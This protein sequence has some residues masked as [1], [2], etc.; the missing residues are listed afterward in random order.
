MKLILIV[1]DDD[2]LKKAL[3]IKLAE[4]PDSEIILAKNGVEG[5]KQALSK[6]PDLILLD[7]IMPHLDGVGMLEKLRQDEWGRQAKVL[8]LTNVSDNE[9]IARCTELGA[10]EYL[11]KA[12]R[13]IEDIA[14]E[15]AS[16]IQ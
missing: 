3:Q 7:I 9:Q 2:S 8:V 14:Q 13:Q 12:D 15:I 1:E 16:K 4:L 5:L 10:E 11:L 6:H